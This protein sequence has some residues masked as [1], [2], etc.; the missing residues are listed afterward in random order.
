MIQFKQISKHFNGT[1]LFKTATFTINNHEKVAIIGKNGSGK[2]TLLK[3]ITNEIDYEGTIELQNDTYDY[4]HQEQHYKTDM[5]VEIYLKQSL[6]DIELIM[7][8]YECLIKEEKQNTKRYYEIETFLLNNEYQTK[9]IMLEQMLTIFDVKK[10]LNK[11]LSTLSGGELA[12]VFLISTLITNSNIIIL[13]EPLNHLDIKA[14]TWLENYL[15]TLKKTL[16]VISHDQYFLDNITTHIISIS[17]Y[18]IKKY[19]GSY[20][21]VKNQ[22]A[23]EEL[24]LEKSYKK[25]QEVIKNDLD[26]ISRNIVRASTTK[27]AQSRQKRLDKMDIIELDL[28]EKTSRLKFEI[29][30]AS[31]FEVL[32]VRNL[33]VGYDNN[34]LANLNFEVVLKDKIALVGENG[35]GKSTLIKTLGR[36]IASLGGEIKYGANVEVAYFDQAFQTLD[37]K[38]TIFDEIHEYDNNLTNFEIRSLLAQFLFTNDDLD[39]PISTLSGGEK[40][41]VAFAKL[42]LQKANFLLLDEPTN[43]LDIE[44]KDVLIQALNDYEGTIIFS[45]HD[46]YFI[47]HV[48]NKIYEIANQQLTIYN[49]EYTSYSFETLFNKEKVVKEEVNEYELQKLQKSLKQKLV[50][51]EEKL[52]ET[53]NELASLVERTF[54]EYD[55]HELFNQIENTKTL[56]STMYLEYETIEE[57]IKM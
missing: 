38:N 40:V 11:N 46:R 19:V 7:Q 22:V 2:S 16:I 48:A 37:K 29:E 44:T 12:K 34:V 1:Y 13:D 26:F 56:I 41:R 6:H 24:T 25:Q 10:L 15:K 18:K 3:M 54:I 27:R 45:S 49:L 8:E 21:K 23:L 17:H 42:T 28:D 20:F 47:N 57:Q 36:Q 33:N 31:G 50:K 4:F 32:N 35:C 9:K 5:N 43:H 30:V 14:I 52:I 51:L 55:N 39:K 53:E